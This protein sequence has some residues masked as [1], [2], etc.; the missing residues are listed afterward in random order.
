MELSQRLIQVQGTSKDEKDFFSYTQDDVVFLFGD[1]IRPVGLVLDHKN[2]LECY[3]LFPAAA[4]MQ[5]IARLVGDPSWVGTTM[6]LGSHKPPPGMLTIVSKLLQEKDVEE[7]EEYEYI[8]IHPLDPRD[9]GD[10]STSRKKGGPAAP[11]ALPHE[12]K[13]M[14]MQELLQFLTSLRQ[15]MKN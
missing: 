1:V 15:D 4:L 2:P 9:P 12:L 14:P 10:H 7:G 13:Q 5:D 11:D 8:P 3:V 6:Q